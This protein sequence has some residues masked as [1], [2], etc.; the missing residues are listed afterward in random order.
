MDFSFDNI[1]LRFNLFQQVVNIYFH[2]KFKF[3]VEVT[4]LESQKC[5]KIKKQMPLHILKIFV[6]GKMNPIFSF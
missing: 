3:N 6:V 5:H 2:F 1:F 4:L